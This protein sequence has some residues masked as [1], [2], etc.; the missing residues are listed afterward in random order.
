M[1][2][3]PGL[4]VTVIGGGHG[5]SRT[6][7]ALCELGLSPTAVVSI[8]D[9]GGSS[10]RLRRDYGGVP[11]GD[12]R[13]ALSTLVR[14]PV[15]RHLLEHRFADG[16]IGGHALG[17]LLLMAAADIHGGDTAQGLAVLS[18]L[19][20]TRGRVVPAADA[21]VDV[22]GVLADGR[23]VHGQVAVANTAGVR[24]VR[25]V[26]DDVPA[27]AAALAAVEEAE[28]VVVGPGSL[29][30]SLVPPLLLP[31]MA[32]TL[33][34]TTATTILVGNI[35]EQPGET[36][37]MDLQAHLDVLFAHLPDDLSLDVLVANSRPHDDVAP[38]LAPL[39]AHARIGRVLLADVADD[40]GNHDTTAL[41]AALAD[42]L[43]RAARGST[44]GAGPSPAV[45]AGG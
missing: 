34:G 42:A 15:A 10:G 18:G 45:A 2:V 13:K 1:P 17:N 43:P 41:A 9:D 14:D 21:P 20:G 24:R 32:A 27:S 31:G 29:L 25:L 12:L 19:F 8:A 26:P 40:A 38:S 28:A 36:S 44:G 30:T 23:V 22:Q 39:E 7:T 35:R 4:R 37:G 5:L 11:P 3:P 33:A 16:E 6:L